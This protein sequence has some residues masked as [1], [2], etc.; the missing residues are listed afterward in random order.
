M[1][2]IPA[3]VTVLVILFTRRVVFALFLGAFAGAII[4]SSYTFM[5]SFH[6]FFEYLILTLT[7]KIKVEIALFTI[8]VGGILSFVSESGAYHKYASLLSKYIKTPRQT[9]FF[10]WLLGFFFFFDDVA[11][12]LITGSSVKP[13]FD[14]QKI[15]SVVLAYFTD[16]V[17]SIASFTLVST[18]AAF[19]ISLMRDA[20]QDFY[21][22]DFTSVFLKSFPFHFYTILSI[23]LG[24]LVALT[25]RWFYKDTLKA[26][27][28]G[29]DHEIAFDP[30]IKVRHALLPFAYMVGICISGIFLLGYYNAKKEGLDI[31]LSSVLG[32]SP[33]IDVLL[34]SVLSSLV[35]SFFY[36]TKTKVFTYGKA[37]RYALKGFK[38]MVPTAMIIIAASVLAQASKDVNTGQYISSF[39]THITGVG[40]PILLFFI[41]V[42]IT[43]ATGSS[44]STMAIIMPVAFQVS[45]N[46]SSDIVLVVAAVISGSIAGAQL[47]P[48]SDKCIIAATSAHVS[49]L[50]HVKTQI[51]HVII[52]SIAGVIALIAY[53]KFHSIF[54]AYLF[55][56]VFIIILFYLFS[57]S[58]VGTSSK[59]LKQ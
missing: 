21:N 43:I 25:G 33:T 49:P 45:Y 42:V 47:V 22:I 9:R 17:A 40:V 59:S 39:A 53:Y 20:G 1:P 19:E 10:G 54:L 12:V 28:H 36:Y 34:F 46:A 27:Y 6:H 58:F 38:D 32:A 50:Y 24:G 11:N 55:G 51:P 2:V 23:F 7:D 35:I 5:G 29:V 18:W 52:S 57:K 4:A 30:R 31:N 56:A 26:E 16:T 41:A 3:I 8:G 14:K 37:I 44:W 48:Y 15:P 13:I